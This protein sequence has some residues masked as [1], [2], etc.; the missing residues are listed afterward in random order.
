MAR[1]DLS[2]GENGTDATGETDRRRED[3]SDEPR[4]R[5]VARVAHFRDTV[6]TAAEW[7]AAT[8]AVGPGV[9][10]VASDAQTTE[11]MDARLAAQ[12]DDADYEVQSYTVGPDDRHPSWVQLRLSESVDP[13]HLPDDL[14]IRKVEDTP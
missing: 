13:S 6:R 3:A 11:E 14:T 5:R 8:D 2:G 12:F 7:R 1:S 9:F 4:A 10:D